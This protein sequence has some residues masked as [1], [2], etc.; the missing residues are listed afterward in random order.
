MLTDLVAL[1]LNLVVASLS[2]VTKYTALHDQ[3]GRVRVRLRSGSGEDCIK[4]SSVSSR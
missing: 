4:E 3:R 1:L 2:G